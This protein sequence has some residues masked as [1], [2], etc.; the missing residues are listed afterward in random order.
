MRTAPAP[1]K[2]AV[3]A[4]VGMCLLPWAC[5][6]VEPPAWDAAPGSFSVSPLPLVSPSASVPRT[7][8]AGEG[9]DAAA[10][11][12]DPSTLAQ[13]R[14]RPQA[15]GPAFDARV[16]SLW[17]A[18]VRDD[19]SRAMPF[20]F[21]LGAYAQVKAIANPEADWQRRLVAN[22]TRDIHRL[23]ERLGAHS[24]DARFLSFDVANERARWVEPGE[25][26]NKVGYFRV[27]GT[28][29]RYAIGDRPAAFDVSSLI[30]W[31]GVWYVVHLS[32]FK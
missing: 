26:Y 16:A 20:F 4:L 2:R 13:T 8:D 19:P 10:E 29:L 9:L 12:S 28:K 23:H 30:S 17:D 32:G 18:I 25:E 15:A 31:R 7:P 5:S 14:D 3:R 21:P 24:G 27:Y 6:H 22:Y 11:A 1:N